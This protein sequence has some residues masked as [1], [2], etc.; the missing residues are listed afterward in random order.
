MQEELTALGTDLNITILGINEYGHDSSN[1]LI[2]SSGVLPMLQDIEDTND[3]PDD[4]PEGA[5]ENSMY[6]DKWGV[7]YRDVVIIG[8]DGRKMG[9]YNLT[10]NNL[11]NEAPYDELK[12]M[13]VEAATLP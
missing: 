12:A 7:T 3:A 8:P 13:L 5:H 9:V 1:A 10:Q 4:V 11:N 6:W 2:A